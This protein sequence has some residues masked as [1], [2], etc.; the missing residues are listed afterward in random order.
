MCKDFLC[1][2]QSKI[3]G[4]GIKLWKGIDAKITSVFLTL[5]RAFWLVHLAFKR[6]HLAFLYAHYAFVLGHLAFWLAHFALLYANYI[7]SLLSLH[8]ALLAH[9][10]FWLLHVHWW[11]T[12]YHENRSFQIMCIWSFLILCLHFSQQNNGGE[13]WTGFM[14]RNMFKQFNELFQE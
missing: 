9:L 1:P 10:A 12:M 3:G 4:W 5:H 14:S 6:L 11:L 7:Y 8:R 2:R 13:C